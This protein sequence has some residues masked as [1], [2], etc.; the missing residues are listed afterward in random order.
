MQQRSELIT[1]AFPD[2]VYSDI[3]SWNSG[4]CRGAYSKWKLLDKLLLE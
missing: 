4:L 1:R 2:G 3:I